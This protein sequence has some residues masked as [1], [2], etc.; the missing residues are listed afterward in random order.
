MLI[1]IMSF[2]MSWNRCK[3]FCYISH[4]KKWR[5]RWKIRIILGFFPLFAT[6]KLLQ[7]LRGWGTRHSFNIIEY[8][9]DTKKSCQPLL[10]K[11]IKVFEGYYRNHWQKEFRYKTTFIRVFDW[12]QGNF[13]LNSNYLNFKLKSQ[14]FLGCQIRH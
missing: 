9:E 1:T 10:S 13:T 3:P 11:N 4:F 14:D 5:K 2:N 7:S 12:F 8:I 6:G